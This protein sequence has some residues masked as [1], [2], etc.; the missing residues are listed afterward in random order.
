MG[1]LV[2]GG[3][4]YGGGEGPLSHGERRASSPNGGAKAAARQLYN[5]I[6]K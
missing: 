3:A 4:P 6:K 1:K 2:F 5:F